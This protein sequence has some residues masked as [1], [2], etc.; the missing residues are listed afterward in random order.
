MIQRLLNGEP[1][2]NEEKGEIDAKNGD[3]KPEVVLSEVVEAMQLAHEDEDSAIQGGF[4]AFAQ[5]QRYR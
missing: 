4:T 3:G 1:L 5:R 2:E